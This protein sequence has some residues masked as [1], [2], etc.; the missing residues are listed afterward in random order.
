MGGLGGYDLDANPMPVDCVVYPLALRSVRE[1]I[2][3]VPHSGWRPP[4]TAKAL[5]RELP[6]WVDCA[7][8]IG[9]GEGPEDPACAPLEKITVLGSA[10]G[11]PKW[12]TRPPRRLPPHCA[13]SREGVGAVPQAGN[14]QPG[15]AS[16]PRAP[17]APEASPAARPARTPQGPR[18]GP[19]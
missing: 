8:G 9:I 12:R 2:R 18:P 17:G 19:A 7:K 14:A 10:G 11:N 15:S 5:G 6:P 13:V 4:N 16:A 3:R 1:R